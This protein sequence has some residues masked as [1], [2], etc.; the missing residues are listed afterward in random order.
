MSRKLI[1]IFLNLVL[2]LLP[3]K[4]Q[5]LSKKAPENTFKL[6]EYIPLSNSELIQRQM[7]QIQ[8]K[9]GELKDKEQEQ[10]NFIL[11]KL[12]QMR[13]TRLES[14]LEEKKQDLWQNKN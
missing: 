9:I 3:V 1:V 8:D 2:S 12:R 6:G 14:Q 5:D 10:S 4:A 11:E 13:I 7:H